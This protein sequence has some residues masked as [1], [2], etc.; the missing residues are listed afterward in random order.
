MLKTPTVLLPK[1][2]LLLS[3]AEL[4]GV[5][6]RIIHAPAASSHATVWKSSLSLRHPD[7]WGISGNSLNGT[8]PS[9]P[10]MDDHVICVRPLGFYT[11][12]RIFPLIGIHPVAAKDIT[13][14]ELWQSLF[15]QTRPEAFRFLK[16]PGI[17]ENIFG[18]S[19]HSR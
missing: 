7:T 2:F 5:C 18:S 16:V 11:A 3:G 10:K 6:I 13:L 19:T 12:Q 9:N 8:M 17:F 1:L 15:M 4:L 14:G